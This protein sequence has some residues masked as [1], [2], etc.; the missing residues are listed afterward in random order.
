MENVQYD[1]VFICELELGREI[2]EGFFFLL[3]MGELLCERMAE[4]HPY[5]P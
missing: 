2:I 5:S 4:G 1:L 3:S